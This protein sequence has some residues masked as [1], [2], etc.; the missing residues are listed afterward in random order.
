MLIVFSKDGAPARHIPRALCLQF[1]RAFRAE[2]W[3][4]GVRR[5][6]QAGDSVLGVRIVALDL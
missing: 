4:S 2:L 5:D 6:P 1:Y 3:R